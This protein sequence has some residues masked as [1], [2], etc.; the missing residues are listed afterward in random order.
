MGMMD[1]LRILAG[2][3]SAYAAEIVGRKARTRRRL[4]RLEDLVDRL[5]R[6]LHRGEGET[7]VKAEI[8]SAPLRVRLTPSEK[9]RL[10]EAASA[11]QCSMS[12]FVRESALMR[13]QAV[14]PER[15]VRPRLDQ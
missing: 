5:H 6:A 15:R 13:A 11:G 4:D 12:A 8:R 2:M 3:I 1:T 10:L 9:T 7:P 14:L